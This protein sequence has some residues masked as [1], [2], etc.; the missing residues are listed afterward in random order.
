MIIFA[1]SK[2][3]QHNITMITN[4]T[5]LPAVANY[6]LQCLLFAHIAESFGMI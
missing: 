3:Q 2:K 6:V 1:D 4:N 5:P